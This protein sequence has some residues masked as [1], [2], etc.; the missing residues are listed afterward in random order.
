[1]PRAEP[2]SQVPLLGSSVEISCS[3]TPRSTPTSAAPTRDAGSQ[4][5]PDGASLSRRSVGSDAVSAWL[6]THGLDRYIHPL[7]EQGYDRLV[8]VAGMDEDECE[9]AVAT[10]KMPHPHARA[11]R[12][13]VAELRQA[14]NL[15]QPPP[16]SDVVQAVL[17]EPS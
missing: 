17:A 12:A 3:E 5:A 13:A 4:P 1:M 14:H 6:T 10:N 9:A 2:S 15:Q 7:I 8:L 16:P 11:F